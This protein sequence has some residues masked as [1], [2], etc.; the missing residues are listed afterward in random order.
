MI[1]PAPSHPRRL[2]YLGTPE[3]AVPPLQALHRAGFEIALVVTRPDK[4]RGR[5]G[6]LAPSPVKA[7]AQAL[8]LP[9]SQNPGDAAGVGADLGVVV[10]YGRLI[11]TELLEVLPMVNLHF[12]LLP[13]WRGAAP[14]ERAILA[15]DTETG[16]CLMV[17]APE[18][19]TGDVYAC[20]RVA[21]EP[22]DT[23]E[24]LRSRLVGIGTGLLVDNLTAGLNPP[25]PQE[26][27]PVYADKIEPHEH[28]LQL[29][30]PAVVLDRVIRLGRAWCE[31]RGRRL[32]VLQAELLPVG[33][34]ATPAVAGMGPGALA[35][36]VVG[37]GG[38]ALRLVTVQPEG[39]APMPAAAWL[40]GAQP[41]P[42][43]RLV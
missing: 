40:N 1:P 24:G 39:K 35:G 14:V 3:V 34:E 31:F 16:V 13:R 22:T 36:P 12:S 29:D 28:R 25:R 6:A 9:V 23:L 17:V 30:R 4:R 38:G 32:K 43:D 41:T 2:V 26:G 7:A 37:T 8:G 21:I 27:E 42:A 20:E 5:G 19:D 33:S 10:A 18:L 11:R 15:G